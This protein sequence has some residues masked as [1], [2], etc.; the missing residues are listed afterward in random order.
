[1]YVL[2]VDIYLVPSCGYVVDD[3]TSQICTKD[4]HVTQNLELLILPS[5]VGY[6]CIY[7]ILLATSDQYTK[8]VSSV[9]LPV[10]NSCLVTK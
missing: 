1:M 2:Y 9:S 4:I 6:F 8:T 3:L 5:S 10:K 7:Q